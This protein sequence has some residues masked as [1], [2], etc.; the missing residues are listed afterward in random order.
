[1][2]NILEAQRYEIIKAKLSTTQNIRECGVS[3]Q[4][5]DKLLTP[6]DT[7]RPLLG[8]AAQIKFQVYVRRKASS[9]LVVNDSQTAP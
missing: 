6:V 1:L 9:A 2:E 5:Q 3:Q 7:A 4:Y 8:T